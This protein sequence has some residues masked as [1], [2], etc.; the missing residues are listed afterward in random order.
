MC[1]VLAISVSS[2]FLPTSAIQGI[3][4][5]ASMYLALVLFLSCFCLAWL[6]IIQPAINQHTTC[7]LSPLMACWRRH[8]SYSLSPNHNSGPGHPLGAFMHLAV[9]YVCWH[10]WIPW[11]TSHLYF[12]VVLLQRM[13]ESRRTW[14]MVIWLLVNSD[15]IGQ[16]NCIPSH[17]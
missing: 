16:L 10:L 1:S 7:L 11:S 14:N 8:W 17:M 6:T 3:Y 5:L 2:N 13:N 12:N 15:C 4:V 9:L